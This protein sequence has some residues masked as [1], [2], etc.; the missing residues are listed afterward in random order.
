MFNPG[1]DG[2]MLIAAALVF[3]MTPGLALFYGGMVNKKNAVT[4]MMQNFFSA[5]WT[6]VLW[7]TFGF[8]LAFS[9]DIAG[10]IGNLHYAFLT[11]ISPSTLFP[12]ND[13]ISMLTFMVYQLMFAII[14]PVLMTG[15]FADRMRFKAFIVFLTLWLIFV[16]FPLAHWVWGGGFL[17]KW[18]VED[19]AGG[20]VV[21]TSAGFGALAAVLYLGKRK[22]PK[23]GNHSLPLILIGTALLWFGW[24]GFNAGSALRVDLDT[25]VAFV[26]TMEAAAFAAV[27]WMFWDYWRT[28]RWSAIGFMAGSIAGLAT[29]T[30][31]AGFVTP[32]AAMVIGI[33]AAIVCHLAVDYKNR[34]GWDDALDVWGVHGMGGFTGII[35]LGLFGSSAILGSNGLI[36]GGGT[37]FL[38]E[39]AAAIFVAIYAFVISYILIW[40]TDRIT[41]VRVPEEAEK[42]GLDEYE[43][44]EE[45]YAL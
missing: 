36:Y 37:F 17:A 6:T 4:M 29:V 39:T 27:T 20:L 15:A 7:V 38:K 41:P 22:F 30:P 31:A 34:K 25:N 16:Y 1:S 45:A 23:E 40:I 33:V 13:Q 44:A 9:R 24:F 10:V 18:G 3:I 2:F 42:V 35:L 8:S 5:G 14:T 11:H 12:G 28:G 43:W 21:H 26:N 19:F 32:Q